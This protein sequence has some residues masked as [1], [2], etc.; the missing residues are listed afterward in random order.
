MA[1]KIITIDDV[2]ECLKNQIAQKLMICEDNQYG[3]DE[4]DVM[5]TLCSGQ[6]IPCYGVQYKELEDGNSTLILTLSIVNVQVIEVSHNDVMVESLEKILKAIKVDSHSLC[7]YACED[8]NGMQGGNNLTIYTNEHIRNITD[9]A[10]RIA[11]LNEIIG[12]DWHLESEGLYRAYP[13]PNNYDR[14]FDAVFQ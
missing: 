9:D 6:Q 4:D 11:A 13:D 5:V 7:I 2:R 14:W 12:A 3:W 10:E 1:T 8:G